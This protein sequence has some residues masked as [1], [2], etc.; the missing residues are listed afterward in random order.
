MICYPNVPKSERGTEQ[1][2][3]KTPTLTTTTTTTTQHTWD[4]T[5]CQQQQQ[6][7]KP[8]GTAGLPTAHV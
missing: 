4:P 2:N 1:K 6:K 5:R 7:A 3:R 8:D